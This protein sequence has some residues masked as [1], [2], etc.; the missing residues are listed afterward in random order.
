MRYILATIYTCVKDIAFFFNTK[1]EFIQ[2]LNRMRANA[3]VNKSSLFADTS[4]LKFK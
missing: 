1:M 2:A 4:Q 3:Q